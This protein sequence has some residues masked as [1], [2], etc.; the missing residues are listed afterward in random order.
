MS[1]F[2]VGS[3]GAKFGPADVQTLSQWAAQGRVV[4]D[5]TIENA[6]NG[7]RGRAGEIPGLKFPAEDV[8]VAAPQPQAPERAPV[9]IPG[10]PTSYVAGHRDDA[11]PYNTGQDQLKSYAEPLPSSYSS[12]TRP[13][14]APGEHKYNRH[15]DDGSAK[16]VKQAW[17]LI[18][19]GFIL[20]CPLITPFGAYNANRARRMGNSEG[21]TP[22][23][24]GMV[25]SIIQAVVWLTIIGFVVFGMYQSGAFEGGE[26]N[27]NIEN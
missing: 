11:A 27:F 13:A 18:G 1:F 16:L 20:A 15:V 17:V 26:S 8:A 23:K 5:T 25:L 7:V 22:Y 3:D 9:S 2:V 6:E 21:E 10:Q 14:A 24:V 12:A 4:R 19:I